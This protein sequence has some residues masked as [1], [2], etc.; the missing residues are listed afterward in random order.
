MPLRD[1]F[2]LPTTRFGSG[3]SLHGMWPA[4]IVQQLRK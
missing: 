1:H 3:E 2:C 4:V